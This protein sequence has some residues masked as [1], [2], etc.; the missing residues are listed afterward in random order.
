MD[1]TSLASAFGGGGGGGYGAGPTAISSGGGSSKATF[2]SVN[3]GQ[4][5]S[6]GGTTGE[7]DGSKVL[8]Y[9]GLAVVG[10]VALFV[11]IKR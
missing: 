4:G 2:G 8:L 7:G 5:A 10:I 6:V 11:F 1:W 3:F 9:V